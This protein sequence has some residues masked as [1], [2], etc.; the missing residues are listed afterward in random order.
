MPTKQ[1]VAA[2]LLVIFAVIGSVA[3]IILLRQRTDLEEEAA[4]PEG[5][6]E[7]SIFPTEGTFEIGDTFPVSV[8][9]NTKNI[10]INGIAV[11]LNYPYGGA[12]PEFVTS[13]IEI[14]SV[15]QS[16]GEWTCPTKNVSAQAGTVTIEIACSNISASG[17]STN[18]ETLFATF[19]LSIERAPAFDPL[20]V[21]FDNQS[22]ISPLIGPGSD[23]LLIPQSTGTYTVSGSQPVATAT[24]TDVPDGTPTTQPTASPTVKVT[25][26][27]TSTVSAQITPTTTLPVAGVSFP[28]I[29]GI[30]LGIL[31]IIGAFIL[32]L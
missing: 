13:D 4:V 18:T 11:K 16:S 15:L 29:I 20:V 6:A 22:S 5:D 28:T 27:P 31:V 3:G 26:A 2:L 23:I 32:A 21:R 17:Y 12:T 7:V 24:P 1:K 14:N 8:F 19:N 30:G 25:A 10:A 9:F